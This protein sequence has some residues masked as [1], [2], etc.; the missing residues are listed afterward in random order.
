MDVQIQTE[1][2]DGISHYTFKP[3]TIKY[4]VEANSEIGKQIIAAK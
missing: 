4:A 2:I 3:N 1:D